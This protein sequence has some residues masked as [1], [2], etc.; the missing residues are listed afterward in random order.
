MSWLY[1]QAS[2][3]LTDPTGSLQ[4]KGYSGQPPH[5]NDPAAQDIQNM[6]PIPSGLW[7]AV[8]LIQESVK[9]GPYVIRLEPYIQTHTWGRSGFLMHGERKTPPFGF[10]SDGCII[11]SRDIRELFWNSTDHD[12]EVTQ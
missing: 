5:T 4:G 11:M 10:A 12:L 6:G 7:Q 1:E 9:H 8:E 3:R 2:G